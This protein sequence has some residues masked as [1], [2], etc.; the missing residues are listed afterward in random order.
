MHA[1]RM[2]VSLQWDFV[3]RWMKGQSTAGP[4]HVRAAPPP[5]FRMSFA[6]AVQAPPRC[7]V[8]ATHPLSAAI[9]AAARR[10]SAPPAADAAWWTIDRARRRSPGREKKKKKKKKVLCVD[11]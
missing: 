10:A 8:A 2:L 5:R 7:P 9:S 11:T 6:R 1:L 4:I 3:G